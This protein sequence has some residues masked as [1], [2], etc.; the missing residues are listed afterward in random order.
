MNKLPPKSVCILRLSAIGDVTHV[1]PTLH[2]LRSNW[3]GV[4]ISWIIGRTEA[5]LV[6]DI[7]GV[8]FIVFD[9]SRG[10]SAYRE[11]GKRLAGRRFD[12]LLHMQVSLRASL[13]SLLVRATTRLGFDRARA[14]NGQ[15]LFTNRRIRPRADQHVL[16]SFLEFPRALG[17]EQIDLRWDIPVPAAAAAYVDE[18]IPQQKRFLAINPCS[19]NRARNWRNWEIDAYAAIIDHAWERYGLLTVLTGGPD[20]REIAY[21]EQISAAAKHPPLSTVG[22]TSLKQLAALLQRAEL[23]IAPDTGPAHMANAMGTPVIG[24]Y[25]SSNPERTGPYLWRRITVNKYPQALAEEF[26]KQV[27]EVRWGQRVR[28]PAVMGLIGVDEVRERLDELL[29]DPGRDQ[30]ST[31]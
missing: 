14:R 29:N 2:T 5:A 3:P 23:L 17:L 26:G 4:Q 7:E 16:D 25:A 30:G 12:I 20:A 31:R 1:L 10:L 11:L 22:K 18:L 8:E 21:A 28:N 6:G 9:K 24:L 13:A 15:W 27:S 19:S